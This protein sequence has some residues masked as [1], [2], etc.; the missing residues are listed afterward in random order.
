MIIRVAALI[1]VAASANAADETVEFQGHPVT[2]IQISGADTS[3]SVLSTQ[4]ATELAVQIARSGD[5]YFWKSRG[6]VPMF[7]EEAGAFITYVALNGSGYVR[8]INPAL[9]ESLC[10][11]GKEVLDCQFSY[12]EHLTTKVD[13]LVQTVF[14][15]V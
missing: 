2:K 5:R 9:K 15:R 3:T 13:P 4:Q 10:S 8:V 11:P 14:Y 1:L 6:N 7:K 12:I